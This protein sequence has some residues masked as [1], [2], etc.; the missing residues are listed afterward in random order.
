MSNKNIVIDKQSAKVDNKALI[1]APVAQGI[2]HWFPEPGVGGS[3]PSGR[4][5]YP[6][7]NQKT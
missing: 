2:E 4:T 6:T 3:N 1:L 5:I 7:F